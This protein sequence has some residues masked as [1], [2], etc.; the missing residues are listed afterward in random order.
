MDGRRHMADVD[1]DAN[2]G[3]VAL[4]L[5]PMAETGVVEVVDTPA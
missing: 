5:E 3:V 2:L 4:V 1:T